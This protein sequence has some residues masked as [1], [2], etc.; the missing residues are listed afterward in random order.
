MLRK[1]IAVVVSYIVTSIAIGLLFLAAMLILGIDGTLRPNE[2]WTTT[3]FNIVVLAG[4]TLIAVLGGMLCSV[5]ARSWKPAL[6][7][8]G[9]MIAYG[10]FGAVQNMNKPDPPAR[11][12][13][14]E[15]QTTMEYLEQIGKDLASGGKEPIWFSFAAP[16]LG[17]GAF[18]V[19][20]RLVKRG[21]SDSG[22]PAGA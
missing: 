2:Y 3:T 7:V 22:S 17:A 8:A 1:V 10:L 18:V 4:G 20:S 11:T 21:R 16:L 19:G 6:V 13:K 14:A 5:I 15:G 12:P 9:I